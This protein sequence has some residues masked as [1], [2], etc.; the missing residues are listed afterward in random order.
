MLIEGE[1]E[2]LGEE[3]GETEILNDAERLGLC[4]MLKLAETD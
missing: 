2:G 4:D 3:E 1:S